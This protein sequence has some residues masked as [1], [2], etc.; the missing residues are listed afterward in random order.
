MVFPPTAFMKGGQERQR[1]LRSGQAQNSASDEI[2]LDLRGATHDALRSAVEVV[3]SE[4][5]SLPLWAIPPIDRAAC[6][7]SCSTQVMSNLSTEPWGPWEIPLSRSDRRRMTCQRST[8][9]STI[10]PP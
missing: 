9:T 2:P 6:P 3:F 10:T 7:T 5:S 8:S 1:R 4:V